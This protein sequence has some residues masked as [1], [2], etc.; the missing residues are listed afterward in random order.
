MGT[1]GFQELEAAEPTPETVAQV[2]E[3]L[4]RLLSELE[5]DELRRIAVAKME[6]YTNV[7]IAK[8]LGKSVSSIERKLGLIRTIWGADS[9]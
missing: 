7:E 1:K 8:D 2:S 6:G 4:R 5:D 9:L 3:E